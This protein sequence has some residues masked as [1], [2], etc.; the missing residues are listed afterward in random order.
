MSTTMSTIAWKMSRRQRKRKY[1]KVREEDASVKELTALMANLYIRGQTRRLDWQT[2]TE[3][4]LM[5]DLSLRNGPLS[6]LSR[7]VDGESEGNPAEA[8]RRRPNKRKS[9]AVAAVHG[10]SPDRKRRKLDLEANKGSRSVL[11]Q[12][13]S[14][15]PTLIFTCHKTDR[16]RGRTGTGIN[17]FEISSAENWTTLDIFGVGRVNL[18]IQKSFIVH[19]HCPS[20]EEDTEGREKREVEA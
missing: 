18:L 1:F 19:R 5:E 7:A 20:R 6:R 14:E 8:Q 12:R 10:N 4:V 3:D 9:D 11:L 15:G 16:G 17:L 13:T 2:H